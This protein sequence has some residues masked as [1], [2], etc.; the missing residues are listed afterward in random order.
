[1]ARAIQMSPATQKALEP[2]ESLIERL[3]AGGYRF[4]KSDKEWLASQMN[5]SHAGPAHSGMA[6]GTVA[7]RAN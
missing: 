6:L 4:S 1:M 3:L 2:L 7:R 5:V